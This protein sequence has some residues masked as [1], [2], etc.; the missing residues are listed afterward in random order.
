MIRRFRPTDGSAAVGSLDMTGV[1]DVASALGSPTV[2][3]MRLRYAGLCRICGTSL[4]AR[5]E[6]IY[7]R[8]TKTVRCLTCAATTERR[9]TPAWRARRLGASSNDAGRVMRNESG[10][11]TRSWAA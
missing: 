11:A 8:G 1:D 4:D 5:T 3:R 7:E 10:L 9:S 6:A 2:K